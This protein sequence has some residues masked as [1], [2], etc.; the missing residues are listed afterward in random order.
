VREDELRKLRSKYEANV[1]GLSR[2]LLMPLPAWLPS[3]GMD[4]WQSSLWE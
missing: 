2:T 1:V 3:E 4:A